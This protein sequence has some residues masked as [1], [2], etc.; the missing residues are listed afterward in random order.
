MAFLVEVEAAKTYA[1]KENCI[2]AVEKVYGEARDLRYMVVLNEQGR[3]YP[4]FIG[5]TALRYMVHFKG[6]C[7]V[8]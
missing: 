4:V 1:T 3:W 8:G 5:E 7:V 2:K 6:W